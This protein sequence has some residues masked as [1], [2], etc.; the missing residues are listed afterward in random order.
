MLPHRFAGLAR[1]SRGNRVED[2]PVLIEG[3]LH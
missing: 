1:R 3:E 2:A